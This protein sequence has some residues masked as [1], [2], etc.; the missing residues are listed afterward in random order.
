MAQERRSWTD[1]KKSLFC[2]KDEGSGRLFRGDIA[3]DGIDRKAVHEP[4]ELFGGHGPEFIG[5]TG[6]DE[7]AGLDPLVKEK[8][9]ITFPEEPLDPGRGPSAELY[10]FDPPRHAGAPFR[11]A[12]R[13][14][15]IRSIPFLTGR[16]DDHRRDLRSRRRPD[17]RKRLM[18][19][20]Q[21]LQNTASK[22]KQI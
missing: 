16:P 8:P 13:A 21:A 5:R 10:R 20:S 6:P 18:Q 19:A 14:W 12:D 22:K 4:A 11:R 17:V 1:R 15:R 3:D 2:I 9:A 7:M